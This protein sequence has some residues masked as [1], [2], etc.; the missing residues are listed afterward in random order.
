M[1]LTHDNIHAV[2][3]ARKGFTKEQLAIFGI[4]WPPK[5]GWPKRL[6]GT[7]ISDSDYA[8]LMELKGSKSK[9]TQIHPEIP[10]LK[11]P[12]KSHFMA[13]QIPLPLVPLVTKMLETFNAIKH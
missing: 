8:R 4:A 12:P 7:E 5:K 9:T 2:A 11:L 1:K 10:S 3:T 13:M 6:I